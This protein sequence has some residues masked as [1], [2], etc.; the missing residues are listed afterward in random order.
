MFSTIVHTYPSHGEELPLACPR[1]WLPRFDPP[2]SSLLH[3]PPANTPVQR[4]PLPRGARPATARCPPAQRGP[5]QAL[6][7]PTH[8]AM[9]R[10][11]GIDGIVARAWRITSY[12]IL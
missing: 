9:F 4:Q 8:T 11:G 3:P 1:G 2:P 6:L 5:A 7:W 12:S 10:R